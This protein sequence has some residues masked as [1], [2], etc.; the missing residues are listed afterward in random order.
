MLESVS[1]HDQP[2]SQVETLKEGVH[3]ERPTAAAAAAAAVAAAAA[4]AARQQWGQGSRQQQYAVS[5]CMCGKS[6]S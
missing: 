4:A 6:K 1:C 5:D 2:L 3:H